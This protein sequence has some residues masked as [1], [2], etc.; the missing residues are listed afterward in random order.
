[1]AVTLCSRVRQVA[2]GWLDPYIVGHYRLEV[3]NDVFKGVSMSGQ[4]RGAVLLGHP[5]L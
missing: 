3:P 4:L 2:P 1:M 5:A